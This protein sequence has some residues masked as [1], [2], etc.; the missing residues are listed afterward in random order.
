VLVF[1]DAQALSQIGYGKAE[2]YLVP[3]VQL[4]PTTRVPALKLISRPSSEATIPPSESDT[5]R[6]QHLGCQPTL[7]R[8]CWLGG[9]RGDALSRYDSGPTVVLAFT[10]AVI[11]VARDQHDRVHVTVGKKPYSYNLSAVVD[12]FRLRQL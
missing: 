1:F 11:F 10:V 4:R 8:V 2:T 3:P 9:W 6:G 5:Q 7:S 12:D